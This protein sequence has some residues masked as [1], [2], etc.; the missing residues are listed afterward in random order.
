MKIQQEIVDLYDE[1]GNSKGTKV[2]VK[3]PVDINYNIYKNVR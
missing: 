1:K 3:I 2:I